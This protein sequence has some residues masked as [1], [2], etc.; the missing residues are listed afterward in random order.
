M[1]RRLTVAVCW[2]LT[3]RD[4]LDRQELFEDSYALSQEFREWLL[5]LDE[6]PTELKASVLMVPA[7]LEQRRRPETDGLLEI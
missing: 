4:A 6:H 5:C 1:Q 2:A 3:R 7:N